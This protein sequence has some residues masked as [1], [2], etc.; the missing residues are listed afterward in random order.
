MGN[1]SKP[2]PGGLQEPLEK[3][4]AVAAEIERAANHALVIGTVLAHEIPAE[5]QV[6]EVAQAIEQT[7]DLKQQLAESAEKL[8]DVSVALEQEIAKQ[9]SLTRELTATREQ[10]EQLEDSAK[11]A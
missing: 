9:R 4:E 1:P 3:T 10:V 8:G 7:E 6:G 5:L 2:A 11:K